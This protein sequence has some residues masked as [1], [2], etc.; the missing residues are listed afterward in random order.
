MV[1][2]QDSVEKVLPGE[3]A[4]TGGMEMNGFKGNRLETAK[5]YARGK[6]RLRMFF[7]LGNQPRCEFINGVPPSDLNKI[8]KHW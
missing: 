6:G 7:R 3:N 1:I 4:A 5:I 2:G 8:Q